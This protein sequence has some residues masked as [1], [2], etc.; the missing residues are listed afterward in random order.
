MSALGHFRQIGTVATPRGCLLRPESG[1]WELSTR[2]SGTKVGSKAAAEI[3]L[4]G[5]V[6]VASPHLPSAGPDGPDKAAVLKTT[7]G[8]SGCPPP[9]RFMRLY[10]GFPVDGWPHVSTCTVWF[11]GNLLFVRNAHFS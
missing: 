9:S 1:H 6:C 5:R 3:F 4:V 11:G 8:Y 7:I 10:R 2:L